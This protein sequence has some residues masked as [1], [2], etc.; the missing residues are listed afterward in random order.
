MDGLRLIKMFLCLMLM[1]Q[2]A[3]FSTVSVSETTIFMEVGDD[4]TLPCL[5]VID[6]QRNCDGTTWTFASRNRTPIEVISFGQIG[7][8]AKNASD[9]L[10]VTANCSL[11]IKT[12]TVED[13]GFYYCKQYESENHRHKSLVSESL[14]DLSVLTLTEHEDN[15]KVTINCSVVTYEMCHHTVKCL[16]KGRAVDRD[17]SQIVTLQTGCSTTVSLLKSHH[18]YSSRD[19]LLDCEVNDTYT[20]GK[21]FTFRPQLSGDRQRTNNPTR[22]PAGYSQSNTQAIHW[23]VVAAVGFV[24]LLITA[25]S[26]IRWRK[27]KAN[28]TQTDE[29]TVDHEVSYATISYRKKTKTKAQV[30]GDDEGD[31]VIY[32]VLMVSSS[33]AA[34]ANPSNPQ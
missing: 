33:P 24:L 29:D 13:V 28:K 32:S 15:D 30:Q 20:E 31:A 2:I 6:D 14:V 27:T 25:A 16:F 7:E 11:V 12:L 17:N 23:Y 1:I 8:K 21:L 4:V 26:V 3:E 18:V 22:N 5:N 9:R 10:S 34:T 19:Y